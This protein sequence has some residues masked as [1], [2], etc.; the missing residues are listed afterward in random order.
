MN[1]PN[2]EETL[3]FQDTEKFKKTLFISNMVEISAGILLIIIFLYYT[4][5]FRNKP[6]LLPIG[7]VLAAAGGLY[8]ILYI[9]RNSIR[10][11]ETPSKEEPLDYF[12]YWIGWYENTH[13]LTRSI[14]WWYLLPIIPSFIA[15]TIGVMQI[16]PEKSIPILIIS[17]SAALIVGG[18]VYWRNRYYA[19]KK[20]QIRIDK[21][22]KW[23]SEL[24]SK[25]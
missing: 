22:H 6:I 16:N 21:L 4:Y 11:G 13:K 17:V 19:S 3:M 12:K 7:S 14:F 25:K 23:I 2:N 24:E 20:L 15:F 18:G 8:I 9:I 10:K 5:L 1:E